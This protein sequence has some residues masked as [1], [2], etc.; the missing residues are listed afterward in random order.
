MRLNE[1]ID[2]FL[3]WCESARR[4]ATAQSYRYLL[5]KFAKRVGDVDVATLKP[6]H[7]S[8]HAKSWHEVQSVQRLFQWAKDELELVDR[9]VFAKVKRPR[10][11]Q[12]TRVLSRPEMTRYLRKARPA[13]REFLTAMRES[14]ARPQEI[15]CLDWAM[16]QAE[17]PLAE[18]DNALREG[19]AMFVLQDYKSRD[20]RTDSGA[21]R[22]ILVNK[23]LGRLLSRLWDRAGRPRTGIIFESE[24]GRPWTRN[25]VRCCMRRLR[26]HFKVAGKEKTVAYTFRHSAATD[27]A[28]A[29]VRDRILAELM[30]HAS[31]RTTARY[32]HLHVGHLRSALDRVEKM[33]AA[34][35]TEQDV[36]Q[37]LKEMMELLNSLMA[38]KPQL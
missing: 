6:F 18:L 8:S 13:F 4:P 16:L 29:G 14:I 33:N 7:L 26:N 34:K 27:K 30:G 36:G 15:R 24:A 23:R 17:D 10:A 35:G 11:G 2:K 32:Q 37:Q 12:R 5:G 38:K 1:L 3:H 20:R 31:T 22:L 21:P 28:A 25:S 9:N 19:A